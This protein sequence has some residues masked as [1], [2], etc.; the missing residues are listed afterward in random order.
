MSPREDFITAL[1]E[2]AA[3]CGQP[4]RM[5]LAALAAEAGWGNDT[6]P[7]VT[8]AAVEYAHA[9]GSPEVAQRITMLYQST[10]EEP[11]QCVTKD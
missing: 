7:T 5:G 1:E 9:C 10:R 2:I 11:Y 3:A 8:A 4:L 6:V